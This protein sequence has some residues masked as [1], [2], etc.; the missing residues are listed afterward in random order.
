MRFYYA[1][2]TPDIDGKPYLPPAELD[3]A[4]PVHNGE[5]VVGAVDLKLDRVV[6][7]PK[8]LDPLAVADLIVKRVG[9]KLAHNFFRAFSE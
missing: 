8:E 9:D 3:V 4:V 5:R 7:L 2:E 1:V 6:E